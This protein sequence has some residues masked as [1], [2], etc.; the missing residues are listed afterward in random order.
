VLLVIASNVLR[1]VV[2]IAA[3]V[4]GI[5][6]WLAGEAGLGTLLL[7]AA[8]AATFLMRRGSA[9]SP[10]ASVGSPAASPAPT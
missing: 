8:L 2:I 9:A 5:A 3:A 4:G 7:L 10:R 1:T 6:F